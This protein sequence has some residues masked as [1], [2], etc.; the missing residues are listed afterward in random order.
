M[1]LRQHSGP[2]IELLV[3]GYQFPEGLADWHDLNWLNVLVRVKTSGADWT[4]GPDPCL[5]T[6][7]ALALAGW[8][9]AAAGGRVVAPL[10]FVEPALSFAVARQSDGQA[11][12]VAVTLRHA[13]VKNQD[14]VAV[15]VT[16]LPLV[17]HVAPA[18]LVAAAAD[19]ETDL[20]HFPVRQSA[21]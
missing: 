9:R 14:L 7:E 10:V 5:L 12:P 20:L 1:I 4:A 8:L 19:L 15:P 6:T 18:D 17:L 16:E 11:V 3:L 21:P 13:F 2:Q